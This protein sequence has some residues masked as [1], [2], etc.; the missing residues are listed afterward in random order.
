VGATAPHSYSGQKDAFG[1]F[2]AKVYA[3]IELTNVYGPHTIDVKLHKPDGTFYEESS[4]AV[5]DAQTQGF[6]SWSWYRYFPSWPITGTE[7]ENTP[8]TWTVRLYVDG[9]YKASISF[10]LG[11]LFAEHVMSEG[12]Q[13]T[14]PYKPVNP[15][16]IFDQLSAKATTWAHSLKVSNPLTMKWIFY[17]PNGSQFTTTSYDVPDPRVSG[18]RY[19]D[20]YDTW[21]W[22]NVAGTGAADKCG[23]WSVDVF[24]ADSKGT[25][26][27]QYSDYFSIIENPLVPPACDVL[28]NPGNP[29]ETQ[30]IRLDLTATD[31]TYLKSAVLY[32][33]DGA[34]QSKSWDNINSNSFS[35][36]VTLEG[37]PAGQQVEYWGVA[38]DTSG[39]TYEGLHHSVIV[40]SETVSSPQPPSGTNIAS[41]RQAVNFST[42]GSTTSLG[43]VVEYQFDW[44]DG[45]QSSYGGPMQSHFWNAGGTFAIKARAR[46]QLRSGRVSDW[47]GAVL[48]SV[49]APVLPKLDIQFVN[50]QFELSWPT[51]SAGFMLQ[52][53]KGL[54]TNS[55]WSAVSAAPIVE[56]Q[57]F[58]VT[59]GP[60]GLDGF[61]RLTN[62]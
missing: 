33:N 31:N 11:Y 10:V 16:K 2:E 6:G 9:D 1:S 44:G 8:G 57:R 62:Q 60:E 12:V 46:S 53:T 24:V 28:C 58:I 5:P 39:N 29:M 14:D 35:Q 55:S 37:Y 13:A 4:V 18:F 23:E 30:G 43:E 61:Y 3:W 22:L 52:S 50:G 26:Q 54:A 56:G 42:G 19:W 47:S 34:L 7:I 27:K 38:T 15:K 48:L 25:F 40:Q 17:E 51:N 49:P 59:V 21:S 20:S 32:W 36:S 45:Q 41:W